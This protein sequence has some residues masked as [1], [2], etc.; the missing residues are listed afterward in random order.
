M[1]SATQD[2]RA[3][4]AALQVEMASLRQAAA[5]A[6]RQAAFTESKVPHQPSWVVYAQGTATDASLQLTIVGN[7]PYTVQPRFTHWH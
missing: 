2:L 7:P 4:N 5:E 6:A 3:A 1:G